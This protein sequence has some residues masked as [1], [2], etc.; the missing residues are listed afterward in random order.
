MHP[1][2][3]LLG[4][5]L[6]IIVVLLIIRAATTA[7]RP[8]F[9]TQRHCP[10]T[11]LMM[12]GATMSPTVAWNKFNKQ[13][14]DAFVTAHAAAATKGKSLKL[15]MVVC[16]NPHLFAAM[17]LRQAQMYG[18]PAKDPHCDSVVFGNDAVLDLDF[19]SMNQGFSSQNVCAVYADGLELP[20]P[21]TA[22]RICNISTVTGR[23]QPICPADPNK[24]NPAIHTACDC[25]ASLMS[26]ATWMGHE[27]GLAVVKALNA[28]VRTMPQNTLKYNKTA[29][30]R[31]GKDPEANTTTLTIRWKPQSTEMLGRAT[32]ALNDA[33][34]A[35]DQLPML[36]FT[37]WPG[38]KEMFTTDSSDPQ[39]GVPLTMYWT[40]NDYAMYPHQYI[41]PGRKP[42]KAIPFSPIVCQRTCGTAAAACEQLS[43]LS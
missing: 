31:T 6:T 39:F 35:K 17:D 10:P 18:L 11:A 20:A 37:W 30:N 33:S 9:F 38:A 15:P 21:T 2:V 5:L 28:L 14:E 27:Q 24:K 40:V 29:K 3:V 1:A 16:G 12:M 4:G 26:V 7:D 19:G 42:S 32:T 43:P 22:T 13:L 23:E 25:T 41:T 34:R 8:P 36:A